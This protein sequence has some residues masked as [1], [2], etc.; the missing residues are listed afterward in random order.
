[1]IKL[2]VFDFDGVFTDGK[3]FFCSNKIVKNYNI[4]DGMGIKLLKD[5]NIKSIILSGFKENESQKEIAEHLEIE[6][7]FNCIDKRS[8]VDQICIEESK[9]LENIAFMGDDINDID[10]LNHV[11]ISGCPIDA[12]KQCKSVCTFISSKKGGEG[13]VR[14]FCEYI[15]NFNYNN[16]K[17]YPVSDIK[18]NFLFQIN[19]FNLIKINDLANT[20]CEKNKNNKI[21]FTGI[22]KSY[23]MASHLCSLLKSINVKCFDLSILNSL[24]GDIGSINNG[25]LIIFF[26]K[27]GN[28]T[29]ML[30][31]IDN[32]KKKGCTLYGI[33]CSNKYEFDKVFDK[34]I[35]LPFLNEI[36][37][38]G[39]DQIPTNSC[40]SQLIFSNILV[41]NI[42]NITNFNIEEY[43]KN[44]SGGQIGYNLKKIKDV[45]I[46]EY[47]KIL[48]DKKEVLL[49][50]NKYNIG[51]CFFFDYNYKFLGILCDSD[52]R[53][54]MMS[55]NVEFISYTDVN[56]KFKYETDL[57]KKLIDCVKM[58]YVP[59]IIDEKLI[60][61]IE[62]SPNLTK[63]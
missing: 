1:M 49:E 25:D 52:I 23:N 4:K 47:P 60:G 24:H 5:R 12:V 59:I 45:I 27:S 10:L 61:Y 51:C 39:L 55:K 56:T 43:R 21:F 38:K 40:M 28:T 8:K 22:G 31:L 46:K 48:I 32:L 44:H 20:I 63:M 17:N 7:F 3:L 50:M 34:T 2:V 54:I 42:I 9:K 14:E 29:E 26:S 16:M 37:N 13:C 41:S 58:R 57:D 53:N 33:T 36:N 18:K 35:V 6:C 19:N 30:S 62:F 11:K 15:L